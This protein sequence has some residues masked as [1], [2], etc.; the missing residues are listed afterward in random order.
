MDERVVDPTGSE[1]PPCPGRAIGIDLGER[2]IGIAVSDSA[3]TLAS[4]RTTLT[5]T[6]DPERDHR[7][8][9]DLV[10]EEEATVVVVGLPLSLDGRARRAAAAADREAE[11]LRVRLAP[12]GVPVV[13]HDERLTTVTAHRAL[14]AGGRTARDRRGVVDRSAAAVL[15]QAWLDGQGRPR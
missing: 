3:R 6:G 13:L 2:R 12:A 1:A 9:V 14:A 11:L 7:A 15:L 4:P 10:A 5:R 8:L